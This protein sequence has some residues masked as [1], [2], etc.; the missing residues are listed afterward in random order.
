MKY[1]DE[2]L[3]IRD[4]AEHLARG[5]GQKDRLFA[6]RDA[7]LAYNEFVRKNERQEA[8]AA[9]AMYEEGL[10]AIRAATAQVVAQYVKQVAELQVELEAL[11]AKE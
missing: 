5:V 11:K 4:A 1:Q 7:I 6:L 3:K 2:A 10:L 9:K 8:E